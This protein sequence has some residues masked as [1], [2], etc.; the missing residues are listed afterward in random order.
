MPI[1]ARA[2][3]EASEE[4]SKRLM[5]RLIVS[6]AAP[7][8]RASGRRRDEPELLQ[9]AGVR[10]LKTCHEHGTDGKYLVSRSWQQV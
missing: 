10:E 3:A 7:L 6:V 9:R 5:D 2:M 1:W 4:R 8:K